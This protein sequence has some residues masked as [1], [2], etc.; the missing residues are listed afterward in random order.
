[1]AA[2]IRVPAA[3]RKAIIDHARRDRPQECC[4]LLV[5]SGA[6]VEY[7]APMRNVAASA[8]RY[9]IDD[10]AHID[11]RRVIRAFQPPLEIVGVYHSHPAGPPRPSPLDIEE[12]LYP[13][14][15][16]LIVGLE[17]PRPLLRAYRIR[18]GEVR[19]LSIR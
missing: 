19:I 4:G 5:G 14:W 16:Y 15:A 17:G 8:T 9:R 6:R 13:E 3:V 1:M 11:L 18:Q 2:S 7:A 10:A 12:A